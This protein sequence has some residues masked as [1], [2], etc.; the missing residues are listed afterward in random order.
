MNKD[1]TSE[2]IENE[3]N[4]SEKEM[5]LK[6]KKYL[7]IFQGH[8]NK[9]SFSAGEKRCNK[10]KK[11]L[12]GT[13]QS[14]GLYATDFDE[15][16]SEEGLIKPKPK[17]EFKTPSYNQ[18]ILEEIL[19][20]L[21]SECGFLE[22]HATVKEEEFPQ[23]KNID[24]YKQLENMIL[25]AIAK[26]EEATSANLPESKPCEPIYPAKLIK[27]IKTKIPTEIISFFDNRKEIEEEINRKLKSR[28]TFIKRNKEYGKSISKDIN[29][30]KPKNLTAHSSDFLSKTEENINLPVK[31]KSNGSIEAKENAE[32]EK[33]E[34]FDDEEKKEKS[35]D[36]EKEAEETEDGEGEEFYF[37]N[38]FMNSSLISK[39]GKRAI[40]K[41]DNIFSYTRSKIIELDKGDSG[42][43]E[44]DDSLSED[45]PFEKKLNEKDI[46][47]KEG[48]EDDLY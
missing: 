2:K 41:S 46:K 44:K 14:F 27:P 28:Q 9:E 13:K 48:E 11:L 39:R 38:F 29:V 18:T 36:E 34:K 17:K 3:E 16:L 12:V 40:L 31:T 23:R 19:A 8:A 25:D 15:C 33:K 47:E 26:V 30:P 1:N 32:E 7:Q 24:N 4:M 35:E 6:I 5:I 10:L 43:E 21:K 37:L 45:D 22:K 42:E 20:F